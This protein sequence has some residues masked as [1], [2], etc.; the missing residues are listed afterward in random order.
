VYRVVASVQNLVEDA[1]GDRRASQFLRFLT[2][3]ISVAT[4]VKPSFLPVMT[5]AISWSAP[6]KP[7]NRAD[8]SGG[9]HFRDR[10]KPHSIGG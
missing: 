9:R 5:I 2:T 10:L 1:H 7:R 3:S 4:I 6:G 8:L